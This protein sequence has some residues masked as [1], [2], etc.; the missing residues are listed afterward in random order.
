MHV[1]AARHLDNVARLV[2]LNPWLVRRRPHAG[3]TLGIDHRIAKVIGVLLGIV[4]DIPQGA[5]V[6]HQAGRTL[7]PGLED[8]I[9]Q[10]RRGGHQ[11]G[12]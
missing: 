12:R 8:I 5:F 2:E 10:G 11:K 4:G 7:L 1:L 6:A 3:V 9:G